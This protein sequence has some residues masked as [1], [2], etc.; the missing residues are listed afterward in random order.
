MY[1]SM[2]ID[3]ERRARLLKITCR[4]SRGRCDRSW[5]DPF[6][7]CRTSNCPERMRETQILSIDGKIACSTKYQ[8]RQAWFCIH[9]LSTTQSKLTVTANRPHIAIAFIKHDGS[10]QKRILR[11]YCRGMV[12][13]N[14]SCIAP[15][16]SFPRAPKI[17]AQCHFLCNELPPTGLTVH[18]PASPETRANL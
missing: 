3:G 17:R 11:P 15:P 18:I 6:H 1:A 2:P 8:L 9:E 5:S 7:P 12:L 16:S 10:G 13:I 14:M 4:Q